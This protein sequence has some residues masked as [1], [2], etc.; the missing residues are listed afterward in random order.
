MIDFFIA[1]LAGQREINTT[2][3]G[4]DVSI[5]FLIKLKLVSRFICLIRVFSLIVLGRTVT[6]GY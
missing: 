2:V 6:V 1:S 5:N 4:Q 3:N